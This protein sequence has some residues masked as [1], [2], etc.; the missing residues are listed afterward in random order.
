MIFIT[1][2]KINEKLKKKLKYEAKKTFFYNF[3]K[4]K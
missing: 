2:M 1:N 3:E 4:V